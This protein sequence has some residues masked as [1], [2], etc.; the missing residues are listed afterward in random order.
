MIDPFAVK[1]YSKIDPR[2]LA[3]TAMAR[4]GDRVAR[5]RFPRYA[6]PLTDEGD[7][8]DIVE[9]GAE[10]GI[11]D[12]DVNA[13]QLAVLSRHLGEVQRGLPGAVVEVGAY[14]G[15]TTRRMADIATGQPVYAVDPY[16]GYGGSDVDL[17]SFRA[18]TA[19][20]ANITHIRKPS[21]AALADLA[22]IP[23]SFVFIDA[24]HDY[25]NVRFDGGSWF[26]LLRPG[27]VIAFH[28]VDE[29]AF[30]GTRRAVWELAR[31]ATLV[32]HVPGLAIL[33]K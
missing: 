7:L 33:R 19:D 26:K 20:A 14:R 21:G 27:G 3:F 12:T 1:R 29:I 25:V 8:N 11:A 4:I 17:A 9:S 30:A 23:I 6:L 31:H 16:V 22:G 32:A 13:R 2:R 5:G 24:V 15:V 10:S 28:D 18:R